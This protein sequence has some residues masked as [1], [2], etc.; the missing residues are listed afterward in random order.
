MAK[1]KLL[2]AQDRQTLFD[3]PAD[4]DSLIRHYCL[5]PTDRL[6]IMVRRREHNRLEF[7]VQ[8]CLMRHPGRPLMA[9]EQPP[10]AMLHYI[11]EQIGANPASFDLYA[12]REETRMNHVAHL[13]GYLEMRSATAE[14]RRATAVI[15]AFRERRVLLPV[16]NTIERMGLAARAIARRRAEAGLLSDIGPEKLKIL[17]GLLEVDAAIGPRAFTG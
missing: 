6:E 16:P 7:A 2:K 1:R 14:D 8:L 15:A 10:Q 11:A 17:D 4:E 13:L 3:I 12:H 9:N 5:S